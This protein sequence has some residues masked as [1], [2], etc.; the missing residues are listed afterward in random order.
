MSTYHLAFDIGA[1]SGRAI[2]GKIND[3]GVFCIDEIHR[4]STEFLEINNKKLVD[5][6]GIYKELIYSI[7][8]FAQNY[9]LNLSIGIDT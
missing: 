5:I 1:N 9:N 3:D 4:F 8:F 6:Y 7:K 2:V